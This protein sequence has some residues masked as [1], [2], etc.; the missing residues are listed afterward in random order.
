MRNFFEKIICGSPDGKRSQAFAPFFGAELFSFPSKMRKFY[1][2]NKKYI[3]KIRYL[4]LT[5]MFCAIAYVVM[6]VL[7]ISGIGGFLTFDIKDAIITVGAMLLGPFTGIIISFLV[8]LLE[9]ITVSG[10]GHWGALMNFV[11]SA[12]FA[13]CASA[14]YNYMPGIRKKM[15]G[16][17]SGLGISIIA[18][19]ISMLGMN[20][21]ITPI[22]TGLSV[23]EVA[24]MIVP[25]LLP[26]NLI[27]AVLNAALVMII[28][29]PV[30]ITLRKS[31]FH[32]SIGGEKNRE[33]PYF[34]KHSLII[35]LISAVVAAICVFL[36]IKVFGGS[37]KIIK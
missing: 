10:T 29:K 22:Y 31:G 23:Q 17:W 5:A 36:L 26:F 4:T 6:F 21:L 25:L 35:F 16:A 30:S 11:S 9:M 1:M 3:D 2:T 13:A 15:T 34:S 7:R 32:D 27:K 33:E 28:Y 8:A 19:T 37:F 12:V 14:T 18:M 24:N 20:L